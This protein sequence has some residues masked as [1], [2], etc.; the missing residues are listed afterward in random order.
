MLLK[1]LEIRN[2][3]K[4]KQAEIEFHGAGVKFIQG[5]NMSG[6]TTV[7]QSIALTM[8]GSKDFTP[9]MITHGEEKAEI[10]AYTDDGLQIRTVIADSVKQTVQK[11]DDSLRRF[12]NVSGGVRAFLNSICSGLEMPWSLRDLTDAKIIEMVK[13]RS[14]VS[15]KIAAIDEKLREK[16]ARR[17][18]A[19]RDKKRMGEPSPVPKVEHPVPVDDLKKEREKA[20]EYL[21]SVENEFVRVSNEIRGKCAFSSVPGMRSL[22]SDIEENA[23][24]I[25]STLAKNKAYTKADVDAFDEKLAVWYEAEQKAAD[26]D[27]YIAAKTEWDR[28]VCLYDDLTL[29]I[30]D[31]RVKRKK[32]LSDMK[33][34][35][36]G[37][38]IGEDNFLYH[39]GAV[40][41]I[42]DTQKTGNWST[43]E[44]VRVFFGLG[45]RFSGEMKVLVVDNAES[46]DVKTTETITK[47]A[48]SAGFLVIMLRV[49]EAPET[50]EEGI[51]YLKEG[52]IATKG[53]TT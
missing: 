51:I 34:G 25:E 29:V 35:V 2:I 16:E 33:L 13:N 43:A 14:G 45:A 6:K 5:A 20:A 23:K 46:L 48:E 42:T 19:G 40:R 15:E 12:V 10:I 36:K 9:G 1:R 41:G 17:T 11:Y 49:A 24:R 31:L 26:Y 21:K 18:E 22:A 32:A 39:N 50:M 8:N 7:A 52:E 53:A 38:E 27:R 37:L 3:R 28:L 30:E 44:S 4:I 47:W